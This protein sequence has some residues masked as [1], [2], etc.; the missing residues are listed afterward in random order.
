MEIN[1]TFDSSARRDI[2]KFFDKEVNSKG[3]IVESS[4]KEEV[5]GLDGTEVYEKEFAGIKGDFETE[6]FLKRDLVSM[7]KLTEEL[8]ED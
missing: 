3:I 6:V 7:M 5:L 2:L 4:S 8:D 1:I